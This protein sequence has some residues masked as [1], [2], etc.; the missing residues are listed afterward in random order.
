MQLAGIITINYA[1]SAIPGNFFA[2]SITIVIGCSNNFLDKLKYN[3]SKGY[4]A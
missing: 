3:H 2:K 1:I 4:T